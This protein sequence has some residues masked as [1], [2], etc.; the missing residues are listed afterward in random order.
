LKQKKG[1]KRAQNKALVYWSL[2]QPELKYSN[3]SK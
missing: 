1:V 3:W 2:L